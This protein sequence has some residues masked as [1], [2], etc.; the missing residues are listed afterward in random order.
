MPS[1]VTGR[2]LIKTSFAL[3][4]RTGVVYTIG[5]HARNLPELFIQDVSLEHKDFAVEDLETF[6]TDDVKPGEAKVCGELMYGFGRVSDEQAHEMKSTSMRACHERAKL[7]QVSRV[8]LLRDV[9]SE[10]ATRSNALLL[11]QARR[12]ADARCVAGCEHCACDNSGE[13]FLY[14]ALD[15]VSVD[16]GT[17]ATRDGMFK[18]HADGTRHL[19]D[20]HEFQYDMTLYDDASVSLLYIG[21]EGWAKRGDP[22]METAGELAKAAIAAMYNGNVTPTILPEEVRTGDFVWMYETD[23]RTVPDEDDDPWAELGFAWTTPDDPNDP[24][25][26]VMVKVL[27]VH[28]GDRGLVVQDSGLPWAH[29]IAKETVVCSLR[30]D[31]WPDGQEVQPSSVR[32]EIEE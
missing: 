32:F 21:T 16:T 8:P 15:G 28:S 17:I 1:V 24:R 18:E 26:L 12:L 9:M 14:R 20:M 2:V 11:A 25:R 7:L 22:I 3:G 30:L 5:R 6:C 29:R 10:D 23:P 13:R 31:H 4:S 27:A 19:M